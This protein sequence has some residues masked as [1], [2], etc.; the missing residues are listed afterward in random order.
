MLLPLLL[1]AFAMHAQGTLQFNQVK[2]VTTSQTVPTGKVWKVESVIASSDLGINNTGT[3][4]TKST[5]ITI[6][7][8]TCYI[9]QTSTWVGSSNSGSNANPRPYG[10]AASEIT[11]LPIWLPAGTTLAAGTN[12]Q[13]IS[14]IEFNIIP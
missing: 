13:A 7:G 12:T 10:M 1:I 9:N 6:G 11:A 3:T 8:N 2:L 14:V 5:Q 4:E